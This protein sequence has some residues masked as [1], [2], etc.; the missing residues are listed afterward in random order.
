[1]SRPA[2][3]EYGAD[4]SPQETARSEIAQAWQSLSD[5][6]M[7]YIEASYEHVFLA[8][9]SH[10]D[11]K[12]KPLQKRKDLALAAIRDLGEPTA[13]ILADVDRQAAFAA[14]KADMIKRINAIPES[15]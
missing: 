3:K 6:G 14:V 13:Y 11:K 4:P 1:M 8:V 5:R 9:V 10:L 2:E 7:E 12:D 15:K